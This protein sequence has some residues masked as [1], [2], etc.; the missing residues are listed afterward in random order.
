MQG[1][2]QPN[3]VV[4]GGRADL[5]SG[6]NPAVEQMAR[7]VR[8]FLEQVLADLKPPPTSIAMPVPTQTSARRE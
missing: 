4:H 6:G 7:E 3:R 8:S 1:H 5:Q 2:S